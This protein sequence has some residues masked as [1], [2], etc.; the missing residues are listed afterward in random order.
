MTDINRRSRDPRRPDTGQTPTARRQPAMPVT[1]EVGR[2]VWHVIEKARLHATVRKDVTDAFRRDLKALGIPARPEVDLQSTPHVADGVRLLVHGR[3]CRQPEERVAQ[4]LSGFAGSECQSLSDLAVEDVGSGVA[5]VCIGAIHR[6]PSTLL[7]P[8][9]LDNYRAALGKVN[10]ARALLAWP[11]DAK[12]LRGMLELV[13]DAGIGIGGFREVA[14][15]VADGE[16]DAIPS[17]HIA[18]RLINRLR[19]TTLQI[20][21]NSGDLLQ[22]T[23]HE[24]APGGAFAE[25]RETLYAESGSLYPDFVLA[26]ASELRS[27]TVAFGINSLSTPPIRLPDH[28]PFDAIASFLASELRAHRGWFISMSVVEERLQQLELACPNLVGAI[29]DRHPTEWLTAVGRALFKEEVSMH[30]L[31]E[32][33]ERLLDLGDVGDAVDVVR[34]NESVAG[35]ARSAI[36]SFPKPR[37]VVSYL[38]QCSNEKLWGTFSIKP[39]RKVLLLGAEL[40]GIAAA[41]GDN[42]GCPDESQVEVLVEGIRHQMADTSGPICLA[43]SSVPMRSVVREFLEPEFPLVPVV[44]LQELWARPPRQAGS[45]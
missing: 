38:R 4:V 31:K 7:G 41:L 33:L 32:V 42:T 2:S 30:D 8:E 39:Q 19:A 14:S 3:R 29:H 6:R 23:A 5:A 40:E 13:L 35:S 11:P 25:L 27:R 37:H 12:R 10:T 44:A 9:Q 26:E 17:E 21:L 28:G 36:G 1:V 20:R 16:L 24:S 18:E 34:I 43:V 45:G 15:I 22:L